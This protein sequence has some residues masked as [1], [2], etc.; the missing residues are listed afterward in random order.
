MHRAGSVGRH[1]GDEG[2]DRRRDLQVD[3]P[4]GVAEPRNRQS[5]RFAWWC[6]G[7][8]CPGSSNPAGVESTGGNEQNV[9]EDG[10]A[11][12]RQE[13]LVLAHE[14]KRRGA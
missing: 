4:V 13:N 5:G 12:N 8:A 1:V 10:D 9:E 2:L 6:L 3:L 14:V 7:D 11:E